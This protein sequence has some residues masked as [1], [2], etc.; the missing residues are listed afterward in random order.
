MAFFMTFY[1][2]GGPNEEAIDPEDDESAAAAE[3][4]SLEVGGVC[5]SAMDAYSCGLHDEHN[6]FP[7]G[8]AEALSFTS[9]AF[10]RFARFFSECPHGKYHN[11]TGQAD[12][13]GQSHMWS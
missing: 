10:L 4:A 6:S 3:Q 12:C 9:A 7:F 5:G 11:E 2:K 8:L 1:L 13:I